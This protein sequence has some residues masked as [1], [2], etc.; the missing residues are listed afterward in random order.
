MSWLVHWF[1]AHPSTASPA[2]VYSSPGSVEHENGDG[3]KGIL[4]KLTAWVL[5][6]TKYWDICIVVPALPPSIWRTWIRSI[7]H[8]GLRIFTCQLE[9]VVL[10]GNYG[11]M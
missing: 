2:P 6:Y 5:E 4:G 10:Q 9:A 1:D 8:L 7:I 11:L 3:R